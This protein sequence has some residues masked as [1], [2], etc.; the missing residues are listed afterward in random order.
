VWNLVLRQKWLTHE[1]SRWS[2]IAI[3]GWSSGTCLDLN[4]DVHVDFLFL[5]RNLLVQVEGFGFVYFRFIEALYYFCKLLLS[6]KSSTFSKRVSF[7]VNQCAKVTTL[8]ICSYPFCHK[9]L[10]CIRNPATTP[11]DLSNGKWRSKTITLQHIWK[12]FDAL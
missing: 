11:T 2:L 3:L 12:L 4:F 7:S 9:E 10:F 8:I 6:H 1:Y 5:I